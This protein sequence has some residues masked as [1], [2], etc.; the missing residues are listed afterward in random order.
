MSN[1]PPDVPSVVSIPPPALLAPVRSL[2]GINRTGLPPRG[3]SHVKEKAKKTARMSTSGH[4]PRRQHALLAKRRTPMN[5]LF[6]TSDSDTSD[7]EAVDDTS[8]MSSTKAIGGETKAAAVYQ[9]FVQRTQYAPPVISSLQ[10]CSEISAG[11]RSVDL[12]RKWSH[13]T[14]MNLQLAEQQLADAE[15]GVRCA[16]KSVKRF[17]FQFSQAKNTLKGE[18]M[19]LAK[20]EEKHSVINLESDC[21]TNISNSG[22]KS[23]S[24]DCILNQA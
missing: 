3:F 16:Q 18:K 12:A 6:D 17:K 19:N 21:D 10:A 8:D 22:L 24:D 11:R 15:N 7:T 5:I 9:P 14:R 23:D 13:N 1:D 2:T 20:L 4:A